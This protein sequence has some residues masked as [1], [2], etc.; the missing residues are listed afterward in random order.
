MIHVRVFLLQVVL[1]GLGFAPDADSQSKFSK[2]C[3]PFRTVGWLKIM[4]PSGQAG[5][6][7]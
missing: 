5:D 2:K 3:R 7:R 4:R 1:S 6:A